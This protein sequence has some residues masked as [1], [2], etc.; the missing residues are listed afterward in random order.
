M[1]LFYAPQPGT[2]A[3]QGDLAK[4]SAWA[5]NLAVAEWVIRRQNASAPSSRPERAARRST[6]AGASA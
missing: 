5:I 4:A 3:V 1:T 2:G 6:P